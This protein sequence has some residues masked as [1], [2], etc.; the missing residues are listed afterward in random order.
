MVAKHIKSLL[1]NH[2]C[3]II[4]EFGGLIT[5]YVSASIHPVKHTIVPPSKMI[6]FNEK[7]ILND[8]LLISTIAYH[9]NVSAAEAQHMVA[10]FVRNAKNTLNAEQKFELNEIGV[11][12]YN[13]ERKLV[14][15]SVAQE[16]L[17]EDS[18]GLPDLIVRP[19]K[20]EEATALRTLL[21][22]RKERGVSHE[23]PFKRRLRKAYRVAAGFALIGLT[24]SALYLLS[25]QT[26]YNLSSLN[27]ISLIQLS[28][29]FKAEQVV[30]RYDAAYIPFTEEE[31]TE[32]YSQLFPVAT[33]ADEEEAGIAAVDE[34]TLDVNSVA[35]ETITLNPD[36]VTLD[37]KEVIAEEVVADPVKPVLLVKEA[38]GRHYVISGGYSTQKNAEI[39]RDAILK[40]GLEAKVLVPGRYSRLYRVSV[41]DYATE[42]EAK[43][44]LKTLRQTFGETI[45]VFKN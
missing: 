33:Q 10:A 31:R 30:K 16:N 32:A 29:P 42:A 9:N 1:Y 13:A 12:R 23:K 40:K 45:W 8:G 7:L 43:N 28:N 22:E 2:D 25:L 39:S 17:L 15:E 36:S 4:P 44:A 14:F 19:V 20:T 6:A 3:V 35:V 24:S 41:A 37:N 21:K 27:P 34:A 18:F 5:R 11:F 38:T 26:D